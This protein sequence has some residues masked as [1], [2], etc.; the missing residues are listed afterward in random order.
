MNAESDISGHYASGDLLERLRAALRE[1]GADPD[2][3][4]IATL[5]PYDQ[6]HGRGLEATEEIA[7]LL[8]V[9]ASDNLLDIGS[10]MGGPARY[11]AHRFGCRV[12]GIDLTAEFCAVARHLTRLLGLEDQITIHQGDALAMPFAEA[13]FEG[14]YSM[15]VSMNI[16]DKAGFFRE[17]HRVLKPGGWL[18]LSELAKGPGGS[19]AFPVPW[20][21]SADSSFLATPAET[22]EGLAAAGFAMQASRDT[23]EES[24]D[25]GARARAAVE[26]GE[27]P[28]HRASALVHGDAD[29]RIMAANVSRAI[30]DGCILPIEIQ[31]RKP[32]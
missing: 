6:F 9:S 4:T 19:I 21:T 29:T 14:A 23:I 20:A 28:P 5:A 11:L 25:F 31:C 12:T 30:A 24:M 3:P 17:I 22:L 13:R 27:K 10:G 2:N 32:G 15:N 16:A 7:G 26:R 8:T 1:D 18:I